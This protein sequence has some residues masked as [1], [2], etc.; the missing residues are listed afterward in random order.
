MNIFNKKEIEL[1]HI[2]LILNHIKLKSS[3]PLAAVAQV[4]KGKSASLALI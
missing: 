2:L 1:V 4:E 3:D